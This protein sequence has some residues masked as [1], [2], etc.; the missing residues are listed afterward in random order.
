[1]STRTKLQRTRFFLDELKYSI[2][3]KLYAD[4]TGYSRLL[5]LSEMLVNETY[6]GKHDKATAASLWDSIEEI[7]AQYQGRFAAE[8]KDNIFNTNART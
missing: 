7:I 1:M 5:A 3:S 8:I 6:D 2:K 4:T